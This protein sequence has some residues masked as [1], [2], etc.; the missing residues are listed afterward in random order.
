MDTLIRICV[1]SLGIKKPYSI[2]ILGKGKGDYKSCAG[3]Y[4]S[5]MR[6]DK[7]IGHNITIHLDSV[8]R[9]EYDI[10]SVIA[11]EF[12][13]ACQAEYGLWTEKYH[14]GLFK[15]LAKKL[16]FV[17]S[18]GGYKLKTPIYDKKTDTE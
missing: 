11:H 15:K 14:D 5:R 10:N 18:Q 6:K 16:E 2:K 7:I 9:A 4:L 3:L 12:I 1:E 17:L 8:I 13:H